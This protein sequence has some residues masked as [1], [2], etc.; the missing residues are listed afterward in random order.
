MLMY[1]IFSIFIQYYLANPMTISS[2]N[3]TL[4]PCITKLW[5]YGVENLLVCFPVK[6]GIV[7]VLLDLLSE[8]RSSPGRNYIADPLI[9][10]E[11]FG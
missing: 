4:D 1:V 7:P 5:L 10:L 9:T 6:I 3:L 11:E 8:L 2:I